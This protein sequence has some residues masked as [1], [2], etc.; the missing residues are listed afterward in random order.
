MLA[1]ASLETNQDGIVLYIDGENAFSAHRVKELLEYRAEINP[2]EVSIASTIA[3]KINRILVKDIRSSTDFT[4]F[5]ST[6][7]NFIVTKKVKLVVIDSIAALVRHE[8][9]ASSIFK[10]QNLLNNWASQLKVT[11]EKFNIQIVVTNQVTSSM[12]GNSTHGEGDVKVFNSVAALG[13]GWYHC[14]NTRLT[15]QKCLPNDFG[16]SPTSLHGIMLASAPP[17]CNVAPPEFLRC[18]CISKSPLSPVISFPYFITRSGIC[19]LKSRPFDN[20]MDTG[21]DTATAFVS[22]LEPGNYWYDG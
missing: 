15:L 17:N 4:T 2:Y 14:V 16:I 11:S 21:E 9:D 22:G 20:A 12:S 18:L 6:L 19:L 13:T 8:F 7:D 5:L 3:D 10:R 1:V